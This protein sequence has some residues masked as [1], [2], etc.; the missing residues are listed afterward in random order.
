V[1]EHEQHMVAAAELV[2]D[3][4]L[5]VMADEGIEHVGQVLAFRWSC[6]RNVR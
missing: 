3:G 4:K 6:S 2:A 1:R 5:S